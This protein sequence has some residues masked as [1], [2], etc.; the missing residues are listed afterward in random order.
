M[1]SKVKKKFACKPCFDNAN[2]VVIK[3][4]KKLKNEHWPSMSISKP[5]DR[6]IKTPHPPLKKDQ[7]LILM[8]S[9]SK[10]ILMT[11]RLEAG[12][13]NT[14]L[15]QLQIIFNELRTRGKLRNTIGTGLRRV[16]YPY[17]NTRTYLSVLF[18]L[19][20]AISNCKAT[21][22]TL[23]FAVT[24]GMVKVKPIASTTAVNFDS[25]VT[26]LREYIKNQ[27]LLIDENNDITD[28][29]CNKINK[30]KTEIERNKFEE[31]K[32][33]QSLSKNINEPKLTEKQILQRASTLTLSL[34]DIRSHDR[35]ESKVPEEVEIQLTVYDTEQE[36]QLSSLLSMNYDNNDQFDNDPN[37]DNKHVKN[38]NNNNTDINLANL[39][40]KINDY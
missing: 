11:R 1:P 32:K 21:E 27:E 9:V 10:S 33:Q 24:A 31:I 23:K 38:N 4:K 22:A 5:G 37:N 34:D 12:C 35:I 17:I 29:L 26:E 15:S 30:L 6:L 2:Q 19:S 14:G 18:C 3:E 36:E 20:P 16:L 8:T 13:I 28:E 7:K 39:K 25:L 40:K